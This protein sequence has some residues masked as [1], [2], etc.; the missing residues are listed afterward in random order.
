MGGRSLNDYRSPLFLAWQLTN[1]CDA[2]CLACCEE[3]G[4]GRAWRDE[5]SRDEALVIARQAIDL[6]VPYVAFGG[7]EPLTVPYLWEVLECLSSAG[8]SIKLETNGHLINR[9]AAARLHG[10][11]VECIQISVDGASAE[12]HE[13]IRPGANFAAA[14][15]AID[16]L[17]ALGSAP[18]CVFVPTRW[19]IHEMGPTFDVARTRGC[20]AFVTGPLMRLGRAA[21]DWSELACDDGEWQRAV[22]ALRQRAEDPGPKIALSIYPWDIITELEIRLESPQA[23]LLIVPDGKV[24]LLNALPFCAGDLRRQSLAET[25][26]AYCHAWRA[27]EVR[28]FIL[29]CRAEPKLLRHANETWALPSVA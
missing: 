19:N 7:G 13:R 3:S 23:M 11:G 27:P 8:I 17:V 24:K 15:G 6:G 9:A 2:Q 20:S 12:V 1:G 28:D 21:R 16:H 5:L 22:Y 10:L 14:L 18:Q 26:S 4:I 29:E 25:W